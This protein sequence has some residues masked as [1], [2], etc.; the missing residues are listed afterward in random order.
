MIMQKRKKTKSPTPPSKIPES[1]IITGTLRMHPR[2]FGFVIPDSLFECPQDVFIPKHLTDNAVDGDH[3]EVQI[4][5]ES[6]SEKGPDGKILSIIKRGRT[7]L[8]GTIRDISSKH[9]IFAHVPL[10]GASKPVIVKAQEGDKPLKIG[11][12]V[13]MKVLDWG[14]HQEPAHCEVSYYIGHISDP[15]CD[16]QAAIEEFDLHDVFSKKAIAEAKALGNKVLKKDL[17]DRKDYSNFE[18]FTIDPDTAKDFDDAL[19]LSKDKKGHF[20]LGVHIADVAHYV[21]VGSNLDKEA[22]LRCNSTYFPG[23]VVPMLPHD[24]SDNLCSL[25]EAEIR[26]TISVMMEFDPE[27]TLLNYQIFRSYIKSKKRMT[28][29]D[30]KLI[31][32]KKME[33]PHQK[34]L[35]LM[36]ELCNLLKEK[37]RAR[38]SIDFALPEIVIV[39][40]SKG[41]PLETKKVE[42]DITHQLVEEFMLK[43]NELV[44]KYLSDHGKIPLYRIHEEPSSENTQ[45]FLT[46]ARSLGFQ[47]PQNPDHKDIQKLFH[48]AKKTTFSQ[49]LSIGFIRSMKLA[50]YSP[51]NVGHFGLALEHYCH[52]T[53][54]IRRYSDLVIQRLLMDEEDEEKADLKEVA[55]RC[56]EQER[57]SFRA[58]TSVKILKKL[59]LLKSYLDKDPHLTYTAMITR[60]K[61]FGIFFEI[62][63]L[64]LEGF[65]HISEIGDDYF[66]YEPKKPAL[67]GRNTKKQ[68][69]I[70]ETIKVSLKAVDFILLES[71]WEM[72]LKSAP[73]KR[74]RRK[75]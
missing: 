18:C 63:D 34:S 36:L 33:S 41:Q 66:I 48:Q 61:P 64:S 3:V 50:Y 71:K 68:Y 17:K 5:P 38:G 73:K 10:L 9:R 26:L 51:D 15:S 28:Y 75:R 45:E 29:G 19:S 31:L 43:A 60:I 35:E 46:L 47:I 55:L 6:N 21:P 52:F 42:Y 39:V 7:H 72:C 44:A 74:K 69:I 8:A 11:D 23:A 32:D 2:G 65:I 40:D 22:Y 13:I 62:Q 56:S 16:I 59:R 30:A 49:Q 25:R 54:P 14:N 57:I 12:R 1:E 70:G 53:S 20:H 24:L 27:G 4:N 58:E 67:I 37:R